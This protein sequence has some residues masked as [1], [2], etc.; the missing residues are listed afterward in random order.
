MENLEQTHLTKVVAFLSSE[1]DRLDQ[2]INTIEQEGRETKANLAQDTRL[3]FDS[4]A[5][6]VDT[7]ANIESGNRQIDA[8]NAKVDRA[9]SQQRKANLLLPQAYFARIDLDFGDAV[10]EP[11]YLG[12]VGYAKPDEENI[13]YDWRTPLADVY[14][15][16]KQGP[17]SYVAN[18]RT[19]SVN[20]TLRRQ[21]QIQNNHLLGVMDTTAAINDPVLLE[22]L[23]APHSDSLK[24]ITTTIQAEQNAVIRNLSA[25]VLLVD[26]VAGSG[27][28]SVLLQRIAYL[29]YVHREDWQPDDFLL[30]TPN[31]I[32]AQY[33][34]DVLPA[35]GEQN[36]SALT[37]NNYLVKLSHYFGVSLSETDLSYNQYLSKINAIL[38]QPA[39]KSLDRFI[40]GISQ[41]DDAEPIIARLQLLWRR[42]VAGDD[43]P[44][45]FSSW[46]PWDPIFR[47]LG[48]AAPSPLQLLYTVL[49]ITQ[50]RQ[51]NIKAL[52]V[53]EVQ[54][55]SED[56]MLLMMTVFKASHLT[57]VGDHNQTL[58][59]HSFDP[60]SLQHQFAVHNR[61][62]TAVSLLTSY[63]STGAITRYF[64]QFS[65]LPN[66]SFI[67]PIQPEGNAP[68]IL[69]HYSVSDLASLIRQQATETTGTFAILVSDASSAQAL[70]DLLGDRLSLSI[71]VISA[72]DRD[73]PETNVQ[74]IPLAIAKGLEFDRVIIVNF[75]DRYFSDAEF[76][77]HR[78]YVA[79]SRATQTLTIINKLTTDE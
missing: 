17:T 23:A 61:K 56:Q 20:L 43:I 13:V 21:F 50:F 68:L 7:F 3:N 16:G 12:K 30:L 27:K 60:Q 46:L 49:L 11:F 10:S 77:P 75:Q 39:P 35:L 9:R 40:P 55:Y 57:L 15:A 37:F 66:G 26:G 44:D 53:D 64:G 6:N 33:I 73:R 1:L 41:T 70:Y 74:I 62:V 45:D 52:F 18:G 4:F 22:I 65:G 36:P 76:G 69:D 58:D 47:C 8:L 78:K 2:L 24:D 29:R 79:A 54:D 32:F 25:D 38:D 48:L 59:G 31:T 63:R 19:I 42:Q 67:R 71:A 14:Y 28:T 34:K 5:D 72:Q 51:D